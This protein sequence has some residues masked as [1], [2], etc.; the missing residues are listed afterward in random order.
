MKSIIFAG[1]KGSRVKVPRGPAAVKE[2]LL[3]ECHWENGKAE[4][5]MT[6]EPEDLPVFIHHYTLRAIGGVMIA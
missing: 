2:E 6:L 4:G 3:Q 1:E 5:A